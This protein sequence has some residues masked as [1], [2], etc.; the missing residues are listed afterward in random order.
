MVNSSQSFVARNNWLGLKLDG[1]NGSGSNTGI[2][3]DPE[4]D[5]AIIGGTA[6]GQGNVFVNNAAEGLDIEGASETEAAM[7]NY[8]GVKAD[9]VTKAA[10]GKDIEITDTAALSPATDNEVGDTVSGA[11]APCDGPCNVIS[12]ATTSGVDL[13]GNARQ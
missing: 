9:G 4:S 7:G 12:G 5:K 6:A 10:N 8:F 1:T 3:L 13:F 2:W 11:A